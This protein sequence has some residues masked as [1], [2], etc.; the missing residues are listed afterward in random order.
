MIVKPFF[1]EW[2]SETEGEEKDS[3][4]DTEE[5]SDQSPES[6]AKCGKAMTSLWTVLIIS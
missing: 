5:L 1:S 2:S 3:E 4:R 6:D